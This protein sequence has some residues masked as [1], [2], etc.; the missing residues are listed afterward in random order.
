MARHRELLEQFRGKFWAFSHELL[1]YR[2]SP[3]PQERERLASEF[4]TLF[5]TQ[6]GYSTC[7]MIG[8]RRPG[9]RRQC[10]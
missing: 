5:A 1:A 8:S 7:W 2:Q 4:D 10:S 6:T 3:T 9:R